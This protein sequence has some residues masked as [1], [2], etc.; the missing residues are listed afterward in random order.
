[1]GGSKTT[2]IFGKSSPGKVKEDDK[3]FILKIQYP[4]KSELKTMRR[5]ELLDLLNTAIEHY[6]NDLG[7]IKA[8]KITGGFMPHYAFIRDR[9]KKFNT[10]T[11][12]DGPVHEAIEA[13]SNEELL[14]LIQL[15]QN[16]LELVEG[17]TPPDDTPATYVE[18][19]DSGVVVHYVTIN[20]ALVCKEC[21]ETITNETE[22]DHVRSVACMERKQDNEMEARGFSLID[23]DYE[24]ELAKTQNVPIE[25]RPSG[26]YIWA[27]AWVEAAISAF[28]RGGFAGMELHEYLD[29]MG[30]MQNG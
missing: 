28:K 12:W 10:A 2:R 8:A 24:A 25:Y 27:P 23:S 22:R 1:M 7:I 9:L 16:T 20:T 17:G 26:F 29:R 13:L 6:T 21:G 14:A 18:I 5:T 11:I 19:R 30:K 3:I 4:S 15:D